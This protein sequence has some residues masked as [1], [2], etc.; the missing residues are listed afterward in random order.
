M[1]MDLDGS[2]TLPSSQSYTN[3]A[4]SCPEIY[5]DFGDLIGVAR[6]KHC[7]FCG[8]PI[9]LG[10]RSDQALIEHMKSK[11]CKT[12]QR[13]LEKEITGTN[14]INGGEAELGTGASNSRHVL[15]VFPPL[16]YG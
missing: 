3:W 11:A 10:L 9:R 2:S 5:F 14:G 6:T 1:E 12:I 15:T 7:A 16:M 4:A 13:V 8:D